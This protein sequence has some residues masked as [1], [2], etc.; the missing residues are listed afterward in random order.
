MMRSNKLE[1]STAVGVYC[2]THDAKATFCMLEFSSSEIIIHQLHVK[3]RGDLVIGYYM[4]IVRNLMV[5]LV[6]TTE[7]KRQFLE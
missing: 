1:Y 2:M 6:P 7:F 4:I 5:Q 3:N